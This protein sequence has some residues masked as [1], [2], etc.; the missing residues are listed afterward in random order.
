MT[1]LNFTV[2]LITSSYKYL[3]VNVP[4]KKK[5]LCKVMCPHKQ[6]IQ[7]YIEHGFQIS[8]WFTESCL[9]NEQ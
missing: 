3:F 6:I 8:K 7:H 9:K 1:K 2:L 5:I 4:T